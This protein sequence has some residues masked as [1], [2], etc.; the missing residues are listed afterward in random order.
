[1]HRYVPHLQLPPYSYVPGMHVHPLSHPDGHSYQMHPPKLATPVELRTCEC[2]LW[3]IDLFNTGYYWEAHEAWEAV[4]Q[5]LG[6]GGEQADAIK[7]LIKLAAAGVKAREGAPIGVARHA[8]RALEL[9]SAADE[10]ILPIHLLA[11]RQLAADLTAHPD[12]YQNQ[13]TAPVRRI[14]A[15]AITTA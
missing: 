3:G 12:A 8:A 10:S 4:W 5:A 7:G 13:E 6:R 1:M 15:V 2:F 14:F 9:L 11:I